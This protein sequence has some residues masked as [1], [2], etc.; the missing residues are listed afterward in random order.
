[1]CYSVNTSITSYLIGMISAIAA[2]Y[3]RQY[4]LGMLILCYCQVQ[5][6]EAIIWKGIDTD[7]LTLN[8]LG[9]L[10]AKYTLPAHLMATGLG[11]WMTTGDV[12]PLVVGIIF[13]V[14]VIGFYLYDRK[15][16]GLSFP[17]NRECMKRECQTNENRLKWPFRDQWY[18]IQTA[19]LFIVFFIYLPKRSSILLAGFFS[20]TF[21]ISKMMYTWT[22]SSIWCFL[23]AVLA[24]LL[25]AINYILI[26]E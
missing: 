15:N 8:R 2:L 24:P 22:A 13:Y 4:I 11:V 18:M 16:D 3:T 25:V 6:A 7:N 1:M 17:P 10:Y 12:R 5:L 23:S 14:G 20:I 9:T 19:I 26:K 21:V